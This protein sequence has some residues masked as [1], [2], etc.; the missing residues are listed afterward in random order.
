MK[1]KVTGV[2]NEAIGKTKQA[3]GRGIGDAGLEA[4][5]KAQEVAGDVQ[6]AVGTAKSKI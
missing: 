3:I 1:D 4:E 5:G 6:R 2:A